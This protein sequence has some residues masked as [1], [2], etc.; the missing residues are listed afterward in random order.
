MRRRLFLGS[1][2]FTYELP[3]N[4]DKRVRQF[5]K[6]KQAN[7]EAVEYAKCKYE[8][9]DVG[10]AFYAGLKGDNWDKHAI[11][12][13]FEG[14][15]KSIKYLSAKES[16]LS[17]AMDKA[18]KSSESG[19]LIR[20]LYFFE[21][22]ADDL[23]ETNEDRLNADVETARSVL[24]D[25][26]QIGERVSLNSLFN[27]DS[28]ENNINDYFRDML[29][30]KGYDEVKDQT[31]HGI[32]VGGK[33]AAEV[34]I[35]LTKEGKEIAIFEGLKLDSVNKAYIKTHIDKE[36]INYNALGTATFVVSYVSVSDYKTFWEKFSDYVRNYNFPLDVK[37][38]YEEK[39]HP[40]AS[41]RVADVILS[42]DGY[43][44][45]TYFITFK[46]S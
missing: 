46:I 15:S 3:G 38:T 5:L 39:S 43:D 40:N 25:L 22:D 34:D 2:D 4:F 44:F 31:R 41:T 9:D 12:I 29:F 45:P 20:K 24:N 37:R 11:D 30:A 19:L 8:Y 21:E 1:F 33:D 36:I 13:T 16:V 10:L 32:S 28:T 14:P 17:E 35:L 27:R 6:Q 23:P 7:D 42:R 26:I 18:I